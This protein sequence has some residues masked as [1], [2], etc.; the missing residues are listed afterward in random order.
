MFTLLQMSDL[1]IAG[2]AG[3]TAFII[4]LGSAEKI[5]NKKYVGGGITDIEKILYKSV[6]PNSDFPFKLSDTAGQSNEG[7]I[8][9][10]EIPD[11]IDGA[12]NI[13]KKYLPDDDTEYDDRSKWFSRADA[14]I[15]RI[16]SHHYEKKLVED[17]PTKYSQIRFPERVLVVKKNDVKLSK[18][19]TIDFINNH[20]KLENSQSGLYWY[21]DFNVDQDNTY[22]ILNYTTFIP[23]MDD[24][25]KLLKQSGADNYIA[26]NQMVDL[27]KELGTVDYHQ[28]N[29][30]YI[31]GIM[32][33]KDLK[34]KG[35]DRCP[36]EKLARPKPQEELDAENEASF[37]LFLKRITE[38]ADAERKAALELQEGK[39]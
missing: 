6:G 32:W 12:K 13:L 31:D 16:F 38:E 10:E 37:K 39:N 14:S 27:C 7:Y 26:F 21:W 15:I 4:A 34:N 1:L 30:H 36:K 22:T 5:K 8:A 29:V 2:L 24:K 11:L 33:V 18:K 19:D 25:G 23:E 28:D 17:N 9:S 20:F 35:Q 3:L